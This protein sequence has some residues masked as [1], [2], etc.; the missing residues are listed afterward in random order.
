MERSRCRK[1]NASADQP[2][3]RPIRHPQYTPQLGWREV[4]HSGGAVPA[5]LDGVFGAGQP[6]LHH[7]V[8]GMQIRPVR[9]EVEAAGFGGDQSVFVGFRGSQSLRGI[10]LHQII[11]EHTFNIWLDADTP[12]RIGHVGPT[13]NTSPIRTTPSRIVVSIARQVTKPDVRAVAFI[14]DCDAVAATTAATTPKPTSQLS[15]A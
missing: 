7:G 1:S 4:A 5:E 2:A 13:D 15:G 11:F 6:T 9:G 3:R 12:Q 8:A 14:A 10:Q